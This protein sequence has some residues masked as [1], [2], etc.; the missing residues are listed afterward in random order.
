MF[1]SEIRR[2]ALVPIGLTLVVPALAFAANGM[3]T[4]HR[5]GWFIK[6]ILEHDGAFFSLS[7]VALTLV[8]I[9][10]SDMANGEE[11]VVQVATMA[12]FLLALIGWGVQLYNDGQPQMGS[13]GQHYWLIAIFALQTLPPLFALR[14]VAGKVDKNRKNG[15]RTRSV[16][17]T[18]H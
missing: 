14:W 9:S 18:N 13:E 7:A 5:N 16:I 11:I 4:T 2:A 12:G 17:Q 15:G 1:T 6:M 3:L 10:L 8:A